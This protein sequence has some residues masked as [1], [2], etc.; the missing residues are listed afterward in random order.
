[1]EISDMAGKP[2]IV[3]KD[4]LEE[5]LIRMTQSSLHTYLPQLIQGFFTT[6]QGH[7]VGVCGELVYQN[8]QVSAVRNI[9]SINIRIAKACPGIGEGLLDQRKAGESVLIISP[10]GGGKTTLLRDLARIA[11]KTHRVSVADERYE[12]AACKNGKPTFDLGQCDI[13][14]GGSKRDSIALLVRSMNPEIIVLDEITRPEDSE[15]ILEAWGCGCDFF[16]S[17]HG[18]SVNDLYRRPAYQKLMEAGIFHHFIIIEQTSG[19]REYRMQRRE[20]DAE[21]AWRYP[22]RDVLLTHG[23]LHQS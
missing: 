20:A 19:T 23:N 9:S 5:T 21:A 7:R 3:H 6:E 17:A 2:M 10:P 4:E 18:S 14:S 13:I 8:G 22:D 16:T 11:A 12:L 15:A 1:M